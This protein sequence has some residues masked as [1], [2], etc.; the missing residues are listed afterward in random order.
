MSG[1]LGRYQRM[2]DRAAERRRVRED[3]ERAEAAAERER[4]AAG[5]ESAP[6][7]G[8]EHDGH[9]THT[10]AAHFGLVMCSCGKPIGSYGYVIPEGFDPPDRCPTCDARSTPDR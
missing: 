1:D 8:G 10:H 9:R 6:I 5:G 2:A 4:L 7:V 3:R